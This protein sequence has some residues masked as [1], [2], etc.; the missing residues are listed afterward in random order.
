MEVIHKGTTIFILVLSM[1]LP[2]CN[3]E[4]SFCGA[5]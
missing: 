1:I 3:L 4:Q 2:V 5:I